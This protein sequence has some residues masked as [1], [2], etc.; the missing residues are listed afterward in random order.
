MKC[1]CG[2]G[3]HPRKCNLHTKGYQCH[4]DEINL[5]NAIPDGLSEEDEKDLEEAIE[6]FLK[7]SRAAYQE[8][9]MLEGGS[10]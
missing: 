10:K 7:S 2:S 9:L 3:G 1:T 6:N 8:A 4:I 5:W